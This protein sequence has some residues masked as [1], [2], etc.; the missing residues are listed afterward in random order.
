MDSGLG[1]GGLSLSKDEVAS[2]SFDLFSGIEIEN[3]IQKANKIVV[4]FLSS[5]KYM[6]FRII[7]NGMPLATTMRW[8]CHWPPI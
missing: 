7:Q 4:R 8:E 2:S 1:I 6:L 3:S 5:G